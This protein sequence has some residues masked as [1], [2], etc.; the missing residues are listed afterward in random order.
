MVSGQKS[1]SF[2]IAQPSLSLLVPAAVAASLG[3]SL[4]QLEVLLLKL[5]RQ[6]GQFDDFLEFCELRMKL[7][8]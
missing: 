8:F 5:L 6:N 3:F 2:T 4:L 1:R 7:S